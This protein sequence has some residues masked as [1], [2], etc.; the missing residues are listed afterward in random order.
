MNG[1]LFWQVPT[2]NPSQRDIAHVRIEGRVEGI[3][4]W[5]EINNVDAP[6]NE[7]ILQDIA[8]GLWDF[9]GIV[10]DVGGA[11]S[12]PLVATLSVPFDDP[13]PL[14]TFSAELV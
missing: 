5:T 1:R 9:R 2:P 13:S 12:T 14:V 6:G 4:E 10:V 11:E 8:S 3:E 7:L